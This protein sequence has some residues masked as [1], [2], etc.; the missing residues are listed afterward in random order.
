M[1]LH[2]ICGNSC[3]WMGAECRSERRSACAS[4]TAH[5]ICCALKVV[6]HHTFVPYLW[7]GGSKV[8]K[9][10][11]LRHPLLISRAPSRSFTKY[12][13]LT[14]RCSAIFLILRFFPC[15]PDVPSLPK[16]TGTTHCT[17]PSPPLRAPIKS[18]Q[19]SHL[20]PRARKHSLESQASTVFLRAGPPPLQALL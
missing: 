3:R 2:M 7:K 19:S 17:C 11:S 10:S 5:N 18:L 1:F 8:E 13:N 20:Q 9:L 6:L 12:R 15:S 14:R 16:F 4:C